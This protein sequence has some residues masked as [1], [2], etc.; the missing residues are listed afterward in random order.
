MHHPRIWPIFSCALLLLGAAYAEEF[1]DKVQK[2]FPVQPG[3]TLSLTADYGHVEIKT[4]EVQTV[5]VEVFRRV[6]TDSKARAQQIFDD[7]ALNGT[8][9]GGVLQLTGE[10]KTGWKPGRGD[11]EHGRTIC[12]SRDE[13]GDDYVCLE[14]AR[15][16]REHGYTLTIPKKMNVRVDTRAGHVGIADLAGQLD[17]KTR[18]GHVTAGAVSGV[19]NINTAGGHIALTSS[20]GPA[21]LITAGGHIE[22]GDV[23][24]DL[25]AK[26]AG[27]HISTGKV[28]GK[29]R[30]KTA[31]GHISIAQATG[32]I[33]AVTVG[34]GVTAKF[35]GQPKEDSRL[36]TSAG[37]VQVEIA[38]DVKLDVDASAYNGRVYSDYD[39]NSDDREGRR[40]NYSARINGGGPKLTLRTSHG[41]IRLSRYRAGF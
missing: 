16:L 26:T 13:A 9:R 19:T 41:T 39:L 36:E 31:G 35:V 1:T 10:F 27:G 15:E 22:V 6:E 28:N 2:Q 4:A 25:L 29:V 40:S 11:W 32:S 33:D 8:T 30:A 20:G 23:G 37:S 38:G 14:Y 24:G 21:T 17:V 7:F 18:G 5:Q 34:G 3:Q 12:M